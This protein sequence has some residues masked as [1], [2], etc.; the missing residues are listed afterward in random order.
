MG[1]GRLPKQYSSI[2]L[3]QNEAR[4]RLYSYIVHVQYNITIGDQHQGCQNKCEQ[5]Y[6]F[7]NSVT[8]FAGHKQHD[9]KMNIPKRIRDILAI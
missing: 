5:N 4:T 2:A 3:L 7:Q 8:G 9:L 6:N 1:S